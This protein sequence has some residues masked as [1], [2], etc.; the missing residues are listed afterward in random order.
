M[1]TRLLWLLLAF[2]IGIGGGQI[3]L[4]MAAQRMRPEAPLTAIATDPVLLGALS[5][6]ALLSLVWL[7]ILKELPLNTA[8]PFVAF[9][10]AVTPMLAWTLLGEKPDGLYFLGIALIC[11]GVVITQRA[12]HAG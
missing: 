9:S 6:Y 8:Y 11:T 10:F 1:T 7:F 2:P 5:L 4:K 12:V 3:M